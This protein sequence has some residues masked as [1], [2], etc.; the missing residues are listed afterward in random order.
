MRHT[1]IGLMALLT[2]GPVHAQLAAPNAHGVSFAHV[3][4]SVTDLSLHETLWTDL[5]DGVLVKKAGYSAVRVPGVLIF[6]TEQEPTTTSVNTVIDHFGFRVRN[7]AEVLGKWQAQGND[8]DSRWTSAEG[9]PKAY[10]TMPDGIR[11]ELEEAPGL[12]TST[13]MHHV[14]IYSPRYQEL[15]EWYGGLFGA[16]STA[17]GGIQTTVGVPGANLSF[18]DSDE[19]RA[20]SDG[21]AIDHIGFEVEDMDAFAALLRQEGI[22]VEFGPLYIESL[23]LWVAFFTDPSGAL[24]E[25]TQGLDKY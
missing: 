16:T 2:A 7:L 20:P 10:I 17:R 13:E 6:F 3:H 18:S 15:P 12:S 1:S 8:V 14:H 5:F 4:I 25:A 11:L 21:T 9:L 19:P 23:D 24:V 22:E